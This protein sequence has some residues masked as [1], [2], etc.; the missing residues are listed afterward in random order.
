MSQPDPSLRQT[1]LLLW[2]SDISTGGDGRATVTARRLVKDC[3]VAKA[4]AILGLPKESV[5]V[6]YRLYRAGVLKGSKPG[7]IAKRKDGKTSNAKLILDME[8]VLQYREEC[9]RRMA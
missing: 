5:A 3:S 1:T 6:V 4:R 8:S 9:R 2:E 7:A